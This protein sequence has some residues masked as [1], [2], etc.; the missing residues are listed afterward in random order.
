MKRRARHI[1]PPPFDFSWD[2]FNQIKILIIIITLVGRYTFVT[3]RYP[4]FQEFSEYSQNSY[5]KKHL[6][7][8]SFDFYILTVPE[9]FLLSFCI[10]ILV[11]SLDC[12]SI[13][14]L[15][16]AIDCPSAYRLGGWQ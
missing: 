13:G 4:R 7:L 9:R 2:V 8:N 15:A 11:F 14:F 16:S 6:W 12:L 10:D 3:F 5:F 1:P